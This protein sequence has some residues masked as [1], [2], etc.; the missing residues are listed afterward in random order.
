MKYNCSYT[1]VLD[2]ML[3]LG[4]NASELLTFATIYGFSQDGESAF[5]GSRAYLARKIAAKSKGTADNAL[6]HLCDAGLVL[7][8]ERT[9][10]GVK[11]CE[12]RVDV[13]AVKAFI[14]GPETAAEQPAETAA[15]AAPVAP[16][17]PVAPTRPKGGKVML[18]LS[19]A[20]AEECP[21]KSPEFMNAW[22][23]LCSEPKWRNKSENAIR[24]QLR[25]L[26]SVPEIEAIAMIKNAIGGEWQ[27][28]YDLKPSERNAL[29]GNTP[30]YGQPAQAPV[31]RSGVM[32]SEAIVSEALKRM[33]SYGQEDVCH[34]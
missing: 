32:G 2:W 12:Y 13:D 6:N 27:G 21:H 33:E 20:T 30:H 18:F 28:L 3:D 16:V 4:L 14:N 5:T 10:N 8:S 23:T 15:P 31:S 24:M 29:Y 25:K 17:A 19:R 26:A 9:I 34:V 1:V 7:K 11:F 22:V